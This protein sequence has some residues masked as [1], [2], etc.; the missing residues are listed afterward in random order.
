VYVGKLEVRGDGLHLRGSAA[1]QL[2]HARVLP[3]D[4]AGVQVAR[5]GD[6]RLNDLTTVVLDLRDG[7]SIRVA[8][9]DGAGAL[10]EIADLAAELA[11]RRDVAASIVVVQVPIRSGRRERVCELVRD[12]PPFDPATVPELVRHHVFVGDNDVVFMF[13]GHDV[14]HAIER[15][16]RSP[17]VWMAAAAW[18]DCIAGRP[19]L[20]DPHY[21]WE[22]PNHR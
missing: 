2:A 20:I 15:L 21:S 10:F 9:L 8:A 13:E 16:L 17:T 12:G 7:D 3:G 14:K 6:Q 11:G 1:G 5:V 19:T 22:R 4:L 18:K